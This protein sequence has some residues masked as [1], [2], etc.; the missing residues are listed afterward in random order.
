MKKLLIFLLVFSIY[1]CNNSSNQQ[2]TVLINKPVD[3]PTKIKIVQTCLDSIVRQD[4]YNEYKIYKLILIKNNHYTIG[5]DSLHLGENK[6]HLEDL[7]KGLNVYNYDSNKGDTIYMDIKY[8]PKTENSLDIFIQFYYFNKDWT[9]R[10]QKQGDKWV[11]RNV[12]WRIS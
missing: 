6:I 3:Y 5:L 4:H 12:I 8:L 9:F 1:G 2:H 11:I 7:P 10:M